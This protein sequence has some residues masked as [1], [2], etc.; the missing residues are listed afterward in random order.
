M[1]SQRILLI[2]GNYS[3][4]QTGIGKYN[5][6]MMEW[7]SS[8]GFDCTIVTTYPYYPFW[9]IQEPYIKNS[10]WFRKEQK[11]VVEF[12]NAI[13]IYRCP[14]YVPSTPSGFK[15]ILSDLTFFISA[16]IQI[17]PL[18]FHQK[19]DFV[20]SVVP[21]FQLG[22]LSLFYKLIRGGKVIYHIQDLQIDAAHSL[23]MIK[24]KFVVR[25]MFGVERF[26]LKSSDYVSSISDGMI[27]NIKAK[28]DRDI[29]MFP[30]WAN[31]SDFYPIEGKEELKKEF[32]LASDKKVILYSGA[33]G[34]KQGLDMLLYCAQELK[35]NS[36]IQ[37]VICGSGPYKQRLIELVEEL[38][39]SN[40]VF[41]PL[42]PKEKFNNF[43]NMADVHLVLQKADATDLV[44]PSKVTNILSVGGLALI[45]TPPNNSLHSVISKH[46]LGILI[47]PEN[48]LLLTEG[49]KSALS[50][51][52]DNLKKNARKFAEENLTMDN[53]LSR[54]FT[55]L[56]KNVALSPTK[57]GLVS[58]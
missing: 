18:L 22:L 31:T 57:P 37:F 11:R 1:N 5:G 6:E 2:G 43:L 58:G 14:H 53:I 40:V 30:N 54:F 3:P 55:Q 25:L 52:N 50:N 29:L 48:Q 17:I 10:G 26:L 35:D 24:S 34:E 56:T 20:I 7:L 41:M 38:R 36:E 33:I 42:Q 9:K 44:M 13:T 4:E 21:P 16:F 46:N 27:K 12:D 51:N 19:Y 15:R 49:I 23:G 39:L 28:Y 8:K 32:G 47:E 45:T